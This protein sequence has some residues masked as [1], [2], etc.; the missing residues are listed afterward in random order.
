[1]AKMGREVLDLVPFS[2]RR[3]PPC[4]N[5]R[6]LTNR[7]SDRLTRGLARKQRYAALLRASTAGRRS[8][9][10]VSVMP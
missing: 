8:I 5:R 6:E 9:C 2:F 7:H 10:T 3:M 1:M 4:K